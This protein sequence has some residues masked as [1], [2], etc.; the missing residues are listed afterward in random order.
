MAI[1][2][3]EYAQDLFE[4]I[5][6]KVHLSKQEIELKDKSNTI[7]KKD[8]SKINETFKEFKEKIVNNIE[9]I[10]NKIIN[11]FSDN[12]FNSSYSNGLESYLNEYLIRTENFSL[13]PD[14]IIFYSE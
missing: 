5:K 12:L 1:N 13:T 9:N 6:I 14:K 10:L 7:F 2:F 4:K 11:F 8:F 3:K